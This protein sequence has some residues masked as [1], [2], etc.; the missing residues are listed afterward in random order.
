MSEHERD[1]WVACVKRLE[2]GATELMA[3]TKRVT[4]R[5]ELQV[6][7]IAELRAELEAERR[8]WWRVLFSC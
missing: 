5:C 3:V 7:V 6:G 1:E 8:T 4:A 2:A